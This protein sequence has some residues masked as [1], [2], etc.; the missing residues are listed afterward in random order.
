MLEKLL[1][2]HCE[3]LWVQYSECDFRNGKRQLFS[4]QRWNMFN[5]KLAV[6]CFEQSRHHRYVEFQKIGKIHLNLKIKMAWDALWRIGETCT[7]PDWRNPIILDPLNLVIVCPFYSSILWLKRIYCQGIHFD[8]NL[9]LTNS[10][11]S[12]LSQPLSLLAHL[13]C[14]MGKNATQ[15]KKN[16][17]WANQ[18][19]LRMYNF[20]RRCF[21]TFS[22]LT[23][24]VNF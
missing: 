16:L 5:W 18:R 23:R 6:D 4:W 2:Y 9:K 20:R 22:R 8:F 12:T 3:G 11:L 14:L 17:H 13:K 7:N 24:E 21:G 15:T 10:F 1:M 19:H